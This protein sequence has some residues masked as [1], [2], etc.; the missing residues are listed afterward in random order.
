[1]SEK[2]VK[3]RSRR[4]FSESFKKTRVKEYER[5]EYSVAEL[6][7]LYDIIPVVLYRW[8]HK[9]SVYNKKGAIIVEMKDSATQKLKDYQKRIAELERIVGQKQ[10]NIDFLERMI[11]LAE[12]EYKI[13]IKK[14]LNTPLSNGSGKSG[15]K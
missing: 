5:G 4:I 11:A 12:E 7:M 14:N 2:R 6:S 9:F 8:I 10:L 1:M 3:L 15:R 13:A